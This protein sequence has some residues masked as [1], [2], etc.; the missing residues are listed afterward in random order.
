MHIWFQYQRRSRPQTFS[1]FFFFHIHLSVISFKNVKLFSTAAKFD[2]LTRTCSEWNLMKGPDEIVTHIWRKKTRPVERLHISCRLPKSI[3]TNKIHQHQ[4]YKVVERN[5]SFCC[6]FICVTLCR[7]DP[8]AYRYFWCAIN[9][10]EN[11]N[12]RFLLYLYMLMNAE[13]NEHVFGEIVENIADIY[14]SCFCILAYDSSYYNNDERIHFQQQWL[15]IEVM[16]WYLVTDV[17]WLFSRSG[18]S[19]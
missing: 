15:N 13:M 8:C 18:Q 10:F 4:S 16:L 6:L 3:G 11:G 9:H 19:L 17:F 7:E 14:I 5:Q 12:N 2:M 1:Q